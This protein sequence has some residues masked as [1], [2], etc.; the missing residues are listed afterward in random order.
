MTG[1]WRVWLIC[2]IVAVGH[3]ALAQDSSPAAQL[4]AARQA[5]AAGRLDAA[6]SDLAAVDEDRAD[7]NDVDFLRG[8]LAE[9][10]GEHQRAIG[11]FRAI[12]VR[13]PTLS[14]VRLDLARALFETGDDEAALYQFR[15]AEA[16]GLPP[17][18]EV[19]VQRYLA[20]IRRRKHWDVSVS[21][22]VAPDSNVNAATIVRT[23]QIFGLP[24]QL[25][26]S[27]QKAS[28]IG[29]EGGLGGAYQIDLDSTKRLVFGGNVQDLDYAGHQY[30]DRSVGLFIGPRW[31]LG[32]DSEVSAKV[33]GSRRW[34]AGEPYS[35]SGGGRV[36]GETIL[37]P[38]W[39]LDGWIDVEKVEYDTIPLLNGPVAAVDVGATYGIDVASFVRTDVTITREQT[40]EPSFRDMQYLLSVSYYHDL[41]YGFGVLIGA[42]GGLA[43]YD[44]IEEAFGATRHDVTAIYRCGLSNK[45]LN[46]FGFIPVVNYTHTRRTSDIDF[47]TYGRDRVEL[48]L[49]RNF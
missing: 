6:E 14:R 29:F 47:Y 37:D 24:F 17:E 39:T 5:I 25:D 45:Q 7:R 22:G 15:M 28:G 49:S 16:D 31:L 42:G 19:N 40:A 3:D 27:A 21:A 35:W 41:P 33:V 23:I 2:A 48:A 9:A 8:T 4:D 13:D 11:F 34:Y 20:A 1:A 12:L 43:R 38:R 36:D 18:V 10:K 46:L 30:D 32:Q 26:Q 44:Q